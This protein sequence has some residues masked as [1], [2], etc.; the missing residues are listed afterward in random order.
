MKKLTALAI[1]LFLNAC[2]CLR[3]APP[4][5]APEPAVAAEN[6]PNDQQIIGLQNL[7]NRAVVYC[8]DNSQNSAENC[9]R[10]FEE[11]DYVRFRDIPYK[12]ANFDFL[13][14]DTYPTRR[15][16]NSEITSRW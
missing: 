6:F 8:Y 15:W 3:P 7:R 12:T 14:V 11:R 1:L 16:R 5:A 4:P 2:A 10:Y 9:A 13:K